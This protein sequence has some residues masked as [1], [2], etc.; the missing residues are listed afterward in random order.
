[1]IRV[2][3]LVATTVLGCVAVILGVLSVLAAGWLAIAMVVVGL[4]GLVLGVIRLATYLS[5]RPPE[6]S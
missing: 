5:G 3:I 6:V 1:M 2:V 4:T